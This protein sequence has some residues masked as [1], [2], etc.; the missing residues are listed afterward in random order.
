MARAA[1][2]QRR[3]TLAL[4]SE[5]GLEG[6]A[7]ATATAFALAFPFLLRPGLVARVPRSGSSRGGMAA[8]LLAGRAARRRAGGAAAGRGAGGLAA[9]TGDR[10]RRRGRLLARLLVL[11]LDPGERALVAGS[12]ARAAARVSAHD[13][14][15]FATSL[16]P[17][18]ERI[19]ERL[20]EVAASGR[21]ILGP[22]VEAFEARV[23]R[24]PRRAPRGG[25]GQRHGRAH[26]R[27]ARARRG[28]GDEVICPSLTFYATAEAMVNAGARPVF[29]D[30]DPDTALHHR[31]DRAA[32][33]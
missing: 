30:V 23:R 20:A 12:P 31:R 18:R 26:D 7:V 9:V 8:G 3:A 24:L 14:P 33:S 17:H 25:R 21:Y 4:T 27:A 28:P 22:E 1:D 5:L 6:P 15:L 2:A 16:E 29:C 10:R 13:V 19:V 11:W 32:R